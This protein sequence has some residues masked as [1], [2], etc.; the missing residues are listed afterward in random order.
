MYSRKK[1]KNVRTLCLSLDGKTLY[2]SGEDNIIKM[3]NFGTNELIGVLVTHN[4]I[5]LTLCLSKNG[6]ILYSGSEDHSI[7]IW[8]LNKLKEYEIL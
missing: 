1:Y 5:I 3:W 7:R 6:D 8:D 4:K 2:S